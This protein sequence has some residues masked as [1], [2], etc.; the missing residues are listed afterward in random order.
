[1][2]GYY[3][4]D[5]G[6][7]GREERRRSTLG[8]IVDGVVL[9]LSVVASLALVLTLLAPYIHP[10]RFWIFPVLGL[11]APAIYTVTVLFA[12][13]WIIRWRWRVAAPLLLLLILGLFKV[14]L[15]LKPELRRHYGE[16]TRYGSGTITVM[17]YNVRSFYSDQKKWSFDSV[18]MLI[19]QVDPDIVCI[20]EFGLKA[21]DMDRMDALLPEYTRSSVPTDP[22]DENSLFYPVAVYTKYRV[23][24]TTSTILQESPYEG[25]STWVDLQIGEDTVRIINNHLH[26]TS[27]TADDEEFIFKKQFLS[28]TASGAKVKSIVRR[29]HNNSVLR[30]KQADTIAQVIRETPYARIVCGDFNDTPMS[31]VYR[32]IA[33]GLDDAFSSCGKGY[34]YTFRGFM[35]ALRIDYVL[36]SEPLECL[37]YEVLYDAKLSDHYPVVVRLKKVDA[38]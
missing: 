17:T 34:S 38:D 24:G 5:Y 31:Y 19:H 20:Q 23:L 8:R 4:N 22:S 1:M 30:A 25:Q 28:D 6:G 35:D 29:F 16:E 32:T 10:S 11:I 7:T 3:Y 2:S 13:Y 9:V 18:A 26:S 33:K 37:S 14:P 12:L 27:I 21:E 36:Y 15:F